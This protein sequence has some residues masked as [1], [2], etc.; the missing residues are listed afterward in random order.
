M[1]EDGFKAM[2]QSCIQTWEYN[3]SIK[4]KLLRIEEHVDPNQAAFWEAGFC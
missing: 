3:F 2:L 1:N 4:F